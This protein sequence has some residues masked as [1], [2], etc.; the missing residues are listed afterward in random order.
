MKRVLAAVATFTFAV[1]M[2]AGMSWAEQKKPAR[3]ARVAKRPKVDRTA[4]DDPT[5][6]DDG[7]VFQRT[8]PVNTFGGY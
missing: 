4:K 7:D 5:L 8:L 3:H 1:T 2:L 6:A